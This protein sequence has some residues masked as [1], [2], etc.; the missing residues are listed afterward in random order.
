MTRKHDGDGWD[1]WPTPGSTGGASPAFTSLTDT[2]S[3]ARRSANDLML[4]AQASLHLLFHILAA[5]VPCTAH[6]SAQCSG[7]LKDY[8]FKCCAFGALQEAKRRL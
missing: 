8:L 4:V 6:Y 7:T 3:E 1:R 5:L 2:L